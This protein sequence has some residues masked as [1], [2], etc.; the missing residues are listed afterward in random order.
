M[1]GSAPPPRKRRT[2]VPARD[3]G[4]DGIHFRQVGP[5]DRAPGERSSLGYSGQWALKTVWGVGY[6]FE[7][8]GN[9]DTAA[10]S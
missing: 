6:K 1:R 10:K 4:P 7:L 8:L 9:K 2:S 5:I 3:L